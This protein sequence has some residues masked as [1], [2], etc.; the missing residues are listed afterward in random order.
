M[1]PF[2]GTLGHLGMLTGWLSGEDSEL[3]WIE[4]E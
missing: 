4:L 3:W 1:D 2:S